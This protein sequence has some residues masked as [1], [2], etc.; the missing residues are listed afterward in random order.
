MNQVRIYH[1]SEYV[2][3]NPVFGKGKTTNDYGKG[4]YCRDNF[5]I[6]VSEYDVIIGY[7]ADDS[8][9]TFAKSFVSNGISLQQ[10]QLAMR[11]QRYIMRKRLRG[12]QRQKGNT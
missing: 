6:D 12:I 4:F 2:I 11:L 5:L 1:G 10:L 3:D 8:Y 9:F 7:R